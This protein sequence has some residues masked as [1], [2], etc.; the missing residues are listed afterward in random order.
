[1]SM[2]IPRE[3]SLEQA[4]ERA[5]PYHQKGTIYLHGNDHNRIRDPGNPHR[6]VVYP[7]SVATTFHQEHPGETTARDDPRS[8]G[9]GYE[10][11]RTGNPTRGAFERAMAAAEKAKYCVAFSSGSAA[12]SA[13]VHLLSHGQKIICVDDVYGGTQRYFRQIV[14]PSMGIETEFIDFEDIEALSKN[15]SD[16][17][18][19]LLW[20]ETPTN[21]TLKVSDIQAVAKVAKEN[22]CILAVDNTFCSPYFQNPL[23]LGADLCVHSVTKY[24]G[25]HSDT[26]MGVVCCN[27]ENL[28]KKLRFIQNGI[29]A[30]PSPFDC[31]LAHRGLK[32][33]HIRMEAA[34]RNAMA[35]ALF[36]EKHKGVTKVLYPG[37]R[38]H[39]QH[40][41]VVSQ[42]DGFGA[43]I[44]FYC[45]GGREQ[46]AIVVKTLQ[47]FA[48]AESLGAVE[49]LVECPSLMTHASVP[50][51]QRKILG[52]DD[53]LIRLSVGIESCKDLI[54]DLD[55]ALNAA[56]NSLQK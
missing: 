29:G 36:L 25:G 15:V 9:L 8:F 38:S 55:T 44:A 31:F 5:D 56:F 49:S 17:K 23:V 16:D 37:L 42:Q 4:L 50:D 13:V 46:S 53:T 32:T 43:M 54:N 20:L 19:S 6:A 35:I 14:S 47:V 41:L 48:L 10:Y 27:D 34:A 7:I 33:L 21:P 18:V 1:M 22:N 24:I 51:D 2:N 3:E 26:V 40:N 30:V 12:T 11:S 28:Y 39:P 45:V 52:I